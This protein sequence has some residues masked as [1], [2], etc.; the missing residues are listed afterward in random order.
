MVVVLKHVGTDDMEKDRLK[1]SVKTSA[2]CVERALKTR[3]KLSGPAAFRGVSPP[4][5]ALIL[6]YVCL[7][8]GGGSLLCSSMM[9]RLKAR[10][11]LCI[12][13][14]EAGRSY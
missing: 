14:R 5:D 12:I 10:N 9:A 13:S 6:L 4:E 7:S 11:V 3:R 1:M 2:S 8:D